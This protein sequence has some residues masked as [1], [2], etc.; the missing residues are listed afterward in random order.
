MKSLFL[1]ILLL[2]FLS[3]CYNPNSSQS[4]SDLKMISGKWESYEGVQFNENWKVVNNELL[5]GEGFSLNGSDTVFYE[6]LKI[7]RVGDSVYYSVQFS[8]EQVD[9][10]LTEASKKQ[11]LF[12][13]PENEFPK[14]IDYKLEDD[15]TL[16]V[17]ISDM[18]LNK[19]QNFYLKRISE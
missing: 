3:S 1:S 13:N 16:N 12:V 14:K 17:I 18:E 7:H 19:K 8:D 10:L 2:A 4:I 6:R 11:W 5:A 15:T 9:F